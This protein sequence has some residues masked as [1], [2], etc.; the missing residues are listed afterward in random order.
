MALVWESV[1]LGGSGGVVHDRPG[2][3]DVEEKGGNLPGGDIADGLHMYF[4][5]E[6]SC[7]GDDI[8]RFSRD[9]H[10]SLVVVLVLP[11]PPWNSC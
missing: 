10:L 2:G 11:G 5:F 1:R 7:E 3:L 9:C 8:L 6:Y 4:I